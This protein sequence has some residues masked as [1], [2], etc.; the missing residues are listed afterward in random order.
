MELYECEIPVSHW[1]LIASKWSSINYILKY[2]NGAH[3]NE[4][5]IS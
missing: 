3:F 4:T 5:G 2:F 1:Y